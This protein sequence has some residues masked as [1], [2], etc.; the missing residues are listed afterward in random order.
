[1]CRNRLVGDFAIHI[2]PANLSVKIQHQPPKG[3]RLTTHGGLSEPEKPSI[4]D[5][6]GSRTHNHS[7]SGRI[8]R[9]ILLKNDKVE[10]VSYTHRSEDLEGET[11]EERRA[12][13]ILAI[14]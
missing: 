1:M 13:R 11:G 5:A 10:G 3:T 8:S 12:S 2:P 4:A 6:I 9:F 7:S 14:T